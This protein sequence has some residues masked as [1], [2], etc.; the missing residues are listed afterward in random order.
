MLGFYNCYII[1]KTTLWDRYYFSYFARDRMVSPQ[2]RVKK[3][4]EWENKT[5]WNWVKEWE[6]ERVRRETLNN[7]IRVENKTWVFLFVCQGSSINIS[8]SFHFDLGVGEWV[9]RCLV[10][11][12][13]LIQCSDKLSYVG[14][15]GV[16]L[17]FKSLL[18]SKIHDYIKNI[19]SS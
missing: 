7:I 11:P 2:E 15:I 1:L 8:I 18:W 16:N 9:N 10:F 4:C 12:L 3:R 5:A 13:N 14:Y 19:S 17:Y 6:R